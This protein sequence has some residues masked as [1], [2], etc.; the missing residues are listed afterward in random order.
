MSSVVRSITDKRH[1]IISDRPKG[2]RRSGCNRAS[3]RCLS[4]E[5]PTLRQEIVNRRRKGAAPRAMLRVE[6][7]RDAKHVA[8]LRKLW[9][10]RQSA[11]QIARRLGCSRDAVCGRLIRLG[12]K[13]RHVLIGSKDKFRADETP[14]A[15]LVQ[16]AR[17]D[18]MT[19]QKDGRP[20]TLYF[21]NRGCDAPNITSSADRRAV[22]PC[23]RR[24]DRPAD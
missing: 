14:W 16:I 18:A 11:G 23:G 2:D 13:R 15:V 9:A 20:A 12:L 10:A 5:L 3:K 17:A 8:L 19:L 21:L 24:S 22:R 7:A 4:R 1:G 6:N